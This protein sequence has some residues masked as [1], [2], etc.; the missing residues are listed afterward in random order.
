MATP[1]PARNERTA[2]I[3]KKPADLTQFF[4][5]FDALCT[6]HNVVSDRDKI[7]A[8]VI[9]PNYD[10]AQIW[11]ML[12]EFTAATPNY[13]AFKNAVFK[14]YP[15]SYAAPNTTFMDL[16]RLVSARAATAMTS[17][18]ELGAYTRQFRL[19]Q[20]YVK[21]KHGGALLSDEQSKAEYICRFAEPMC[22]YI[23][24]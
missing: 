24:M 2:P 22:S 7:D 1:L 4:A 18:E 16:Q 9:Y 5:D 21:N 19:L 11:Q 6:Q 14:L 3:F 15:G 20:S 17:R 13:E 23:K 12:G 10:D 8:C